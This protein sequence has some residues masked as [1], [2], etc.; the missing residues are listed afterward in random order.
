MAFR[1]YILY[2]SSRNTYYVGNTS[3]ELSERLRK[4]NSN[5]KGFTGKTGDW[6]IV[7]TEELQTKELAYK[8]EREIKSW[9]SRR[10]IEQLIA[11]EH[12]A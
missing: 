4:H 2:S 7:Y 1:V 10:R 8:R 6:S 11:S 3:D 9:K 5:H 12:S